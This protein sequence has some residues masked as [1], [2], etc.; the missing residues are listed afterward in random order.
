MLKINTLRT[1]FGPVLG[2]R[3]ALL[4]TTVMLLLG[5]SQEKT[6][7]K[8]AGDCAPL[9]PL[10]YSKNLKIGISCGEQMAE[11]RSIVGSNTLVK[12]FVLRPKASDRGTLPKGL[13][14]ATVLQ[15]PLAR[16]VTLSSAQVGF[17]TRLGLENAI[18]GVGEGKF[19]ADSVL[20]ERVQ[21]GEVAEVGS[22]PTLSLEKLLALKPDLVMNFATGGAYD[23]YQRIEA[24]GLPLMLTSEWQEEH[25]LAKAEWIKLFGMLFGVDSLANAV[26]EQS[27]SD[28][29]ASFNKSGLEI[30]SP[31]ARNDTLSSLA[32]RLSSSN[33]GVVGVSPARGGSEQQRASEGETS[34]ANSS[35]FRIPNSEL[36][37][38]RVLVGMSYGGVWY[39]PGGNSYTAQLI[40]DAGGCYL[41]AGTEERE[42]R[43][44]LEQ[45]IALADSADIWINPG[46]FS[47][48]EEILGAEPRVARI[49]AFREKK[50]FQNDGRKGPGGG[51]DFYE[52]AVAKP[53]KVL[54]DFVWA[55]GAFKDSEKADST[56]PGSRWYRNIFNF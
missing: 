48:A 39:A 24:L 40:Q 43:L 19:I 27:K 56:A 32:S 22:G 34:P 20:Y 13:E 45:V 9:P 17:M 7:E 30:A 38:P 14:G 28:Y 54:N 18:A 25:P 12:R 52:S 47:T 10:Q 46:M 35:E 29:L 5:C 41:W 49:K 37:C 42:L 23:D 53:E 36:S 50:V 1:F 44:P 51:N 8:T 21:K 15:V 26:Y 3:T 11:I 2:A 6:P 16:A 33:G 31:S 4:A 55:I